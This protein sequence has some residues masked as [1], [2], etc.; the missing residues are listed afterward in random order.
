LEAIIHIEA[1][2]SCNSSAFLWNCPWKVC[3]RIFSFFSF[4]STGVWTQDLILARKA[5]Y[6][7]S[8]IFSPFFFALVISSGR[9]LCFCQGQPQPQLQSSCSREEDQKKNRLDLSSDKI[10]GR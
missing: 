9:V 6:H 10:A 1:M 8:Y 4:G 3:L 5:L 2:L 7:L